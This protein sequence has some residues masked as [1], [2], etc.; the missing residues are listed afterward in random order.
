MNLE[1]ERVRYKEQYRKLQEA[2][3]C[4]GLRPKTISAYARGVRRVA[5]YV[6]RCPDNL[7]ADELKGYFASLVASHSWSTVKLDRNG[8]QF[9]YRHV[10]HRPWDW[11]DIIKP[12]RPQRLPDVL[13]VEETFKLINTTRKLRYRVFFFTVYSLGLRLSEGLQLQIGDIDA[14]RGRVHIRGGK[15]DKDRSVTLP[16][17]TLQVLR[18]FW[19]THRHARLLFPNPSGGAQRMQAATTPMNRGGVQAA[20]KA[21]INDCAIRRRITVH[22]L[23]HS[24]ATHLLERGVDLPTIQVLLGHASIQT[25]VRYTHLT[26]VTRANGREQIEG[27]LRPFTLRWEE[28]AA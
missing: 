7:T 20:I 23:R 1:E 9:F 2:L 18:R 21:A 16:E 22:S 19:S 14:T 3:V 24:C 13:T 4:Q 5:G 10:L 27:L 25:T 15:G 17:K 12:P 11:V 8:I 6:K 26:D 28:E